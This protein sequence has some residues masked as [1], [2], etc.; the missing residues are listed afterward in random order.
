MLDTG[1]V[2]L[3]TRDDAGIILEWFTENYMQANAS[4]CRVYG[5]STG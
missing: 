1:M 5:Q 2:P 3:C 4:K